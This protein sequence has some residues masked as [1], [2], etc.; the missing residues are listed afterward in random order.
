MEISL[1]II[2]DVVLESFEVEKDVYES[3]SNTRERQAVD[4]KQAICYL[5][6]RFGHS[7]H[8]IGKFLN[9]DHSTVCHNKKKAIEFCDIDVEY[10]N[11]IA[12][13]LVSLENI[14]G[15]NDEIICYGW[16]TRDENGDLTLWDE[17]R[18]ER[19]TF[20]DGEGFWYGECPRELDPSLFPQVTWE[21]EPTACKI[22]VTLK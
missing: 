15:I 21:K 4:I 19:D 22:V 9:I 13:A 10:A 17:N 8:A 3:I 1:N 12:K 7:Q 11:K 18:P 5:G 6:Q 20:Q 14:M 2:L 16:I